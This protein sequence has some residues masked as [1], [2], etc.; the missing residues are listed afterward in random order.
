MKLAEIKVLTQKLIPLN[1]LILCSILFGSLSCT[2]EQFLLGQEIA[3]E[4]VD[5]QIIMDIVT[6][7]PT[8]LRIVNE[9]EEEIYS[10][11]AVEIANFSSK[12]LNISQG[13]SKK[14]RMTG[15]L[16]VNTDGLEITVT[17]SSSTRT[18]VEKGVID[19]YPG[20]TTVIWLTGREGCY[21]CGGHR[22]EW[23]WED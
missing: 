14:L 3:A 7:S 15:G 6:S 21:K 1:F 10:I 18:L 22:I 9:L 19:L 8:H 13:K 2:D 17:F 23:G 16:P 11:N 4:I 20:G 12:K 5:M